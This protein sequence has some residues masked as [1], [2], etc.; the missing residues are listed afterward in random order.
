MLMSYALGCGVGKPCICLQIQY[1]D[2]IVDVPV[3]LQRQVP[4]SGQY[5]RRGRF[6][7][8]GIFVEW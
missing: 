5:R 2:T 6:L 1:I 4:T 8:L 7:R 3:V